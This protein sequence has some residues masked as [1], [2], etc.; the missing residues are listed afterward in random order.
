MSDKYTEEQIEEL[1]IQS[2]MNMGEAE[3]MFHPDYGWIKL[4]GEWTEIGLLF[5]DRMYGRNL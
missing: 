4:D 3:S 2:A 1:A 5:L